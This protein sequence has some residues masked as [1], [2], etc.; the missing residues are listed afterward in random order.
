MGWAVPWI[1]FSLEVSVGE[2]S[3][4]ERRRE[5][6]SKSKPSLLTFI[7]LSVCLFLPMHQMRAE[8]DRHA[9]SRWLYQPYAASLWVPLE[10]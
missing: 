8:E 9:S 7:F 1:F 3:I 2:H 10:S 6:N 4:C 5:K